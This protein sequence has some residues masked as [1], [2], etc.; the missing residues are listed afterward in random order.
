MVHLIAKGVLVP[1]GLTQDIPLEGAVF[2][3]LLHGGL[4]IF[5]YLGIA[6]QGEDAGLSRTI[7]FGEGGGVEAKGDCCFSP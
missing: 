3:C 6:G 1:K 5:D 4:A 2:L 7:A